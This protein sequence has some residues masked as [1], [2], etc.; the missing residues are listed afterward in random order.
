MNRLGKPGAKGLYFYQ[1]PQRNIQFVRA[2]L[3]GLMLIVGSVQ[4]QVSFFCGMMDT[5]IHDDC[6]CA[7][8]DVDEMMV[9]DVEPCCEKSVELGID[10]TSD[11]AQTSIKPIQ[12][13]SDVDPPA[14][15]TSAVEVSPQFLDHASI[16]GVNH[17]GI[18]HTAGSSTYLITQRLRI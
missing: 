15:I 16:F 18:S 5:V 2:V 3:I 4:A 13:E 10:A 1:M 14:T 9:T 7:D 17:T 12:F 8:T 11:Q 6:C